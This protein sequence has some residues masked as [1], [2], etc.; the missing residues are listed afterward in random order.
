MYDLMVELGD[1]A[2]AEWREQDVIEYVYI[3]IYIYILDMYDIDSGG[4]DM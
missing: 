1:H 3:Y 2:P 4:I